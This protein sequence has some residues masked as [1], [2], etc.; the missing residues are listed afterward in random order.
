[1]MYDINIKKISSGG[2][3]EDEN[4]IW[5]NYDGNNNKRITMTTMMSL[6]IADKTKEIFEKIFSFSN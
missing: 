3:H 1:M 4:V 2:N 5:I 6:E